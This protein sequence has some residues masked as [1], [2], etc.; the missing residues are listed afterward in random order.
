M[1]YG[2][3]VVKPSSDA[4][5]EGLR[6][7]D[8]LPAGA[9][10]P[11]VGRADDGEVNFFWRGEGAYVDVG[12]YG[13]GNISYYARVAAAGI[14]HDEDRDFADGVLPQTLVSAIAALSP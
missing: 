8:A 4:V 12:F 14:D 11:S 1:E 7:L 10:L 13:D 9:R 6:F 5:N 3:P 2:N